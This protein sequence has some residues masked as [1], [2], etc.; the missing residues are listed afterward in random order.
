MF[1]PASAF[2][3]DGNEVE[4]WYWNG[5]G[6]VYQ[7]TGDIQAL[8]RCWASEP[9]FGYCNKDWDIPVKVHA[10]IAQ[11]LDWTL[12]GKRWDWQVRKPGCYGAD[13][14][15]A[16][17]KSNQHI[18]VDYHGFTDLTAESTSVNPVIPIWYTVSA[19]G[20]ALPAA[21]DPAWVTPAQLNDP[22]EWD[23]V[24]DSPGLHD[25]I[26]FKLW[27]MICVEE[28]NSAC[29]YQAHGNISLK[30]LCQKPWIDRGTGYFNDGS[31]PPPFD[32]AGPSAR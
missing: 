12:S 23:T 1:L 15:T 16:T 31:E 3:G 28:C 8:A 26:Q 2:C 24:Y 5:A 29:E 7:G 14:I 20:A 22:A 4:T 11:W 21:G 32:V 18:L 30:L 10:S 13:C 27:N 6:W 17:L 9:D 19:M 25:G